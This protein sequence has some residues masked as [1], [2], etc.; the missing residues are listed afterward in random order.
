[1]SSARDL[2]QLPKATC[3]YVRILSWIVTYWLIKWLNSRWYIV[4]IRLL[5]TLT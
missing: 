3:Y 4:W 2:K 1:M 5:S